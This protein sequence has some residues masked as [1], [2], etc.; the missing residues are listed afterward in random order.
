MIDIL[1]LPKKRTVGDILD[2]I[3]KAKKAI[4]PKPQ[5]NRPEFP[6]CET[7]TLP[8]FRA[9]KLETIEFARD[10]IAEYR[11]KGFQLTLR[12][13]FYQ[14]VA[15]GWIENSQREY[16][17]LGDVVSD[18][19][20][21]GLIPWNG[22]VDR[23]RS[24]RTHRS[25]ESPA[26][27]IAETAE[28]YQ[29]D[30]WRDQAYRPEVWIEKD[31]LVGVIEDVCTEWRVPFFSCR[32]YSS[33]TLQYEAGKRFQQHLAAGLTPLVLHL[34]D[35]D[36]SGLQMTRDITNRLKMFAQAHIQ[37]VRL[38]LNENQTERLPPNLVKDSDSR[39]EAYIDDYGKECWELDAL[40]PTEIAGLIHDAIDVLVDKSAWH[41]AK[42]HEEENRTK[43]RE[44]ADERLSK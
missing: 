38:A 19:R 36:P 6:G 41:A 44:I 25:W 13:L 32:G 9:E 3:S 24:V 15:R 28:G 18:G 21:G 8:R 1:P 37:V 31:A 26:S 33:Q 2:G 29:E 20:L 16:N 5:L 23:T 7:F 42:A 40:D 34:G 12:Q 14:F 43:L 30:L 4:P 10:V 35:H 22:I 39:S 27:I 17:R 11:A